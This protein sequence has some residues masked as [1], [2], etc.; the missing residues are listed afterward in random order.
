MFVATT[1]SVNEESD[2]IIGQHHSASRQKNHVNLQDI[3]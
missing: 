3:K 1:I 2:D